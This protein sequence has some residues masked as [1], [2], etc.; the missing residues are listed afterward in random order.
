ML[1]LAAEREAKEQARFLAE[2][3]RL[4]FHSLDYE[5]TLAMAARLAL[6]HLGAR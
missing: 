1:T 4:L 3:S 5:T 2:A 6:P